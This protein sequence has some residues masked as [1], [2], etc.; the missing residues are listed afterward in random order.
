MCKA[1]RK[2]DT[3]ILQFNKGSDS[4]SGLEVNSVEDI[5]DNTQNLP[6]GFKEEL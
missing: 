6:S 3:S 2:N 5:A 1:K 4:L